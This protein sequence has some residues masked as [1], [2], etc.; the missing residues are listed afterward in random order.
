MISKSYY[1]RLGGFSY[2][3]NEL[4]KKIDK[5]QMDILIDDIVRFC[6]ALCK[7][8]DSLSKKRKTTY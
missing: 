1:K 4:E 5:Q 2:F 8:C 3:L 7:K 6:N